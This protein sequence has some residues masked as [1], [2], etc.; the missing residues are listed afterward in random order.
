MLSELHDDDFPEKSTGKKS[1][2]KEEESETDEKG[3]RA[4]SKHKLQMEDATPS[5]QR[6]SYEVY[7]VI[8]ILALLGMVHKSGI[9]QARKKK[10]LAGIAKKKEGM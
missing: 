1:G 6:S 4:R 2:A 7:S 10:T 5:D 3:A 9:F 8:S